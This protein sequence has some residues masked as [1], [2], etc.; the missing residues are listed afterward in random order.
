LLPA[1]LEKPTTQKVLEIVHAR[2]FF[3]Q[4]GLISTRLINEM[5]SLKFKTVKHQ[6]FSGNI[7]GTQNKAQKYLQEYRSIQ[8]PLRQNYQTW[9][10]VRKYDS[11]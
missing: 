1:T 6:T 9:K 7:P 10:K 5:L 11:I 3:Q 8:Y 4:Q 2:V